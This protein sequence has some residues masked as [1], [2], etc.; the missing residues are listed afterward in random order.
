VD[1]KL[2]REQFAA[3]DKDCIY[4]DNPGGTQISRRSL[5]RMRAYMVD[6]NANH[7][8]VFRTSQVSDGLV[9]QARQAMAD[10]LNAARPEEIVFGPNMTTLTFNMSRALVRTFK[11]GDV[12]IVTQLDHDANIAPWE[13]AAEDKGCQI[14]RV[15]FHPEDCTLDMESFEACLERKPRLVAFGYASNAV[16]TIN[17]VAAMTEKANAAGA[18]VYI[19]AVQYAPHGPI[20]VQALGCDF[21][22]CSAYK[23]FGPHVGVL[24]GRYD[25]LDGLR[26]YKVRPAPAEPPGKFETGT[27]NFEGVAGLLGAVEYLEWVGSSFGK[28]QG[29]LPAGA[30]PDRRSV[31]KEAM[32]AIRSHERGL[33]QELIKTLQRIN[34]LKVYGITDPEGFDQRVPTFSFTLEGYAPREVATHL[35]NNDIYAWDG[36]YYAPA[37]TERLGLEDRG[38]MVRVGLVHYNTMEEIAWLGEV[39]AGI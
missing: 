2:I 18:L 13:Q 20:D 5:S 12:L 11:P 23:F 17:P 32:G 38:G 4:F 28:T 33:S 29:E 1:V 21:L 22:V 37:V 31:L 14:L 10:F 25:L 8:G 26:A 39:L 7:G 3:L 16:G 30:T 24:Y 15:G 9:L 35:A 34:G 27:G 19:D 36:N 6:S